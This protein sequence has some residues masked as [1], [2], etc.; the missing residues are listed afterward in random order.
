MVGACGKAALGRFHPLHTVDNACWGHQA[1]VFL[2]QVLAG[3]RMVAGQQPGLFQGRQEGI[4]LA[5][6]GREAVVDGAAHLRIVGPAFAAHGLAKGQSRQ[7]QPGQGGEHDRPA[8]PV[9]KNDFGQLVSYSERHPT[10]FV[11]NRRSGRPTG[12]SSSKIAGVPAEIGPE[13]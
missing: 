8:V 5:A 13:L 3:V 6:E 1:A 10:A 2:Q 7:G 9:E 4:D 12:I 11:A